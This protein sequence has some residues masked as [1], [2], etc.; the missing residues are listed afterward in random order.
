MQWCMQKSSQAG[1]CVESRG[2]IQCTADMHA[3]K[4]VCWAQGCVLC[5]GG[6]VRGECLGVQTLHFRAALERNRHRCALKGLEG[7][8]SVGL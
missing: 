2:H 6:G 7:L 1:V 8:G 5:G 3:S 4:E